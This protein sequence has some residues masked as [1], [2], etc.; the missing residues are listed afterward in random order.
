MRL[1]SLD[2]KASRGYTAFIILVALV[3]FAYSNPLPEN[4]NKNTFII[5]H[6]AAADSQIA[7]RTAEILYGAYKEIAYD[8]E[9]LNQDSIHVLIAAS[10]KEFRQLLEGKLPDWTGA[11]AVP[12]RRSIYLRSPRWHDPKQSFQSTAIHELVHV[13]IHDRVNHRPIP[14][15]LDEG[16]AVFYSRENRMQTSTAISKA[17]ATGSLIPLNQVDDVLKFQRIKAELAYQESYSAVYYLLTTYD[18]EALRIILD[19][20]THGSSLDECF[21]QATGS[22]FIGFEQEWLGWI[23]KTH[24]GLWLTD[25]NLYWLFILFLL[26]IV[27]IARKWHNHRTQKRWQEEE[28]NNNSLEE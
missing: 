20:L 28:L 19:G 12:G 21:M 3:I 23:R 18:L 14:R 5:L 16:L 8:L 25:I 1:I 11:F 6:H 24:K 9:L 27:Y 17:L 7:A 2:Y 15:W 26:P 4:N 13:L 10:R 22:T